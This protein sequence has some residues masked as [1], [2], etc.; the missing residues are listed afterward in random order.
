MR[1]SRVRISLDV[2]SRPP[3]A[4]YEVIAQSGRFRQNVECTKYSGENLEFDFLGAFLYPTFY[5]ILPRYLIKTTR[6]TPP[7]E[8]HSIVLNNKIPLS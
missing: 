5:S 6:K 8:G 1:S 4:D 7:Q 3:V 2:G